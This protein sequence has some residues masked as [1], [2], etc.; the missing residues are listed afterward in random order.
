M[1]DVGFSDREKAIVH[2]FLTELYDEYERDL[3]EGTALL[4]MKDLWN[5]MAASFP[6]QE[7]KMKA[8]RKARSGWEYKAA[9]KSLL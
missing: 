1:G 6:G 4:K 9:V 7:K 2:G 8:I 3:S 5:F